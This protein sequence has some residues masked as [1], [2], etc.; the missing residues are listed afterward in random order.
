MRESHIFGHINVNLNLETFWPRIESII[1]RFPLN[2]GAR[3]LPG[4]ALKFF[5]RF[6]TFL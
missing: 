2:L 1:E 5:W 4:Y 6:S 3:Q